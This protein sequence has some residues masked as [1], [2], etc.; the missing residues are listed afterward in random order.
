MSLPSR[1]RKRLD[2]EETQNEHRRRLRDCKETSW[3]SKAQDAG[4]LTTE[5]ILKN[6]NEVIVISD[7]D[8]KDE[9]GPSRKQSRAPERIARSQTV[10]V[11]SFLGVPPDA[12]DGSYKSISN[13]TRFDAEKKM[14][15]KRRKV[16]SPNLADDIS[17]K[18]TA[19]PAPDSA[20]GYLK[21]DKASS[22]STTTTGSSSSPRYL[23]PRIFLTRTLGRMEGKMKRNTITLGQIIDKKALQSA[24]IYSFYIEDDELFAYLPFKP[25]P[26]HKP[27]VPVS[28]LSLSACMLSTGTGIRSITNLRSLWQY[29]RDLHRSRLQHGWS[30]ERGLHPRCGKGTSLDGICGAHE[31]TLWS[32]LHTILP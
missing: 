3:S 28:V 17:F 31:A 10:S 21:L 22:M 16:S 15:Q 2:R 12:K 13:N 8:E 11:H 18:Q 25:F 19:L 7:D 1:H 32:Q 24:M 9:P 4:R 27:D 23:N 26:G 20:D 30:S 29:N 5:G 6:D 14:F